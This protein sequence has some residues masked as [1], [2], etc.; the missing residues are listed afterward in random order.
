MKFTIDYTGNKEGFNLTQL[1]EADIVEDAE[2]LGYLANVLKETSLTL[3]E[4][5][6]QINPKYSKRVLKGVIHSI[7]EKENES[8]TVYPFTKFYVKD[9]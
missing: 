4:Y 3:I 6:K 7:K 8:N 9:E 2:A 1:L 5:L